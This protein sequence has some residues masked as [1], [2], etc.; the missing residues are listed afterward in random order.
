MARV[1]KSHKTREEE[2]KTT[3]NGVEPA[4]GQTGQNKYVIYC[5]WKR[6][7]LDHPKILILSF[8][9]KYAARYFLGLVL[10]GAD[11][12]WTDPIGSRECVKLE[13][14][15][16]ISM[17]GNDLQM[18]LDYKPTEAESEWEDEQVAKHTSRFKYG[19]S[20]E[21]NVYRRATTGEVVGDTAVDRRVV[22][23]KRERPEK[24]RKVPK[25][26]RDTTDMVSAND[27]AKELGVEGREV[28]GV[29][30]SLKLEKP[31]GGWL[32]DKKT[33][34]EI[35]EKVKKGLKGKKK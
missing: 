19:R 14:G 22:K 29:L 2:T 21:D 26:K 25:E 10:E 28:R 7:D 31:E 9:A 17:F 33:A 13:S 15:I 24:D 35:R 1:R 11:Y 34:D 4:Y 5:D 20:S 3:R 12:T 23:A 16:R 18:L 27:I 30:R 8:K 6:E 32:F